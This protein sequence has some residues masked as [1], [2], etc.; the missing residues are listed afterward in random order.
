MSKRLQV[1]VP[2]AEMREIRS[3]ARREQVSVGEW[4]R[5][6]LREAGS[7]RPVHD[8]EQ[9]LEALRKAMEYSFPT[10]DI[11]QMLAETERGYQS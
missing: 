10:A 1:L 7:S 2:D 11:D 4:V 3:L 9:K 6:R 8:R 5:R